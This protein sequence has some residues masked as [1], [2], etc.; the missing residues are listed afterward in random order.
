MRVKQSELW[1]RNCAITFY[2]ATTYSSIF[3]IFNFTA[4]YAEVAAALSSVV[5]D[6]AFLRGIDD[7][8]IW[9][10]V[11]L[12]IFNVNILPLLFN[13]SFF[14]ERVTIDLLVN[15]LLFGIFGVDLSRFSEVLGEIVEQLVFMLI[16]GVHKAMRLV[17]HVLLASAG[18]LKHAITEKTQV[19]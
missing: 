6:F 12:R 11:F 13:L 4:D 2:I 7:L 10:F 17:H 16:I 15:L 9:E 18:V 19:T 5:T 8:D 1:L 14:S 3:M